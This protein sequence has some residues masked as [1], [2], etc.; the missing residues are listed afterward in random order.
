[1]K[2]D[3]KGKC[4]TCERYRNL[5]RYGVCLSCYAAIGL[6]NSETFTSDVVSKVSASH[7]LGDFI[8]ANR[9]EDVAGLYGENLWEEE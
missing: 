9:C 5:T 2:T 3:H 8:S 7:R 4:D 6:N 1:M